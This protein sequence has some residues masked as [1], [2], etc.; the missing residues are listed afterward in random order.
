MYCII[1]HSGIIWYIDGAVVYQVHWKRK[2]VPEIHFS[3]Q[4]KD[5]DMLHAI[6]WSTFVPPPPG[7]TPGGEFFK[8]EILSSRGF[9][10]T[11]NTM[12]LLLK[13]YLN[14][15]GHFP[16]GEVI[17]LPLHPAPGGGGKPLNTLN[18]TPFL[19]RFQWYIDYWGAGPVNRLT[20]RRGG[21][22]L[23]KTCVFRIDENRKWDRHHWEDRMGQNT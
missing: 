15:G 4:A 9:F 13:V 10:S 11:L 21:G 20:Q 7:G 8:V 19:F 16:L 3:H 22:Q 1:Y 6:L 23:Y 18:H 5:F 17:F 14:V 2:W 12:V